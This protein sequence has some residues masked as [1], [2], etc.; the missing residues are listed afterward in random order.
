M[1]SIWLD[2][3]RLELIVGPRTLTVLEAGIAVFSMFS[4]SPGELL[5]EKI[6]FVLL[7]LEVIR[8]SRAQRRQL[9]KSRS[10]AGRSELIDLQSSAKR[11]MRDSEQLLGKLSMKTRK[12]RG[13]K[14]KPCRTPLIMT[15]KVELVPFIS[16]N[17][18]RPIRWLWISLSKS[19]PIQN[20]LSF[21]RI[22]WW[23]TVSKAFAK[24]R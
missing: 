16:T 19:L 7:K 3:D 23:G 24:S 6:K 11:N 20:C 8:F 14:M 13:P 22:R 2:Q 9:W 17:C 15:R 10:R 18:F 21:V 5:P 1:S 4:D 12:S